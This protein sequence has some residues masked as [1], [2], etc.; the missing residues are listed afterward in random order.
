MKDAK[1]EAQKE[2]EDYRKQK[3]DEFQAYEKKVSYNGN[4]RSCRAGSICSLFAS[5]K[6]QTLISGTFPESAG[7]LDL[8]VYAEQC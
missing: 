6:W 7:I 2:I 8:D 5:S 3:E 4:S 1:S